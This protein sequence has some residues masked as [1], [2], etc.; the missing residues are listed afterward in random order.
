MVTDRSGAA[1]PYAT[2]TATDV[3]TGL[4]RK[5]QSDGAGHY[6]FS[7]INPGTYRVA[8]QAPG[9]A[10]SVSQ[11][12]ADG[13]GRTATL[14]FS[15]EGALRH[16]DSGGIGAAG[17]LEPGQPEHHDDARG[18]DHQERSQPRTGP[19]V[20]RAVC[21]GAL[22]NTAGSSNDA[23]APGGYGNVEF[24]GLPAT[25]NGYILHGYDGNDPWLGMNI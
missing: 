13:L 6:L 2:V 10:T 3:K 5:V 16:A 8:V 15:L 20:C 4:V 22:M 9:F 14:S 23:K 12:M 24:N 7:Q 25:S 19:H 18:S 17:S 11:P 21:P 1:I